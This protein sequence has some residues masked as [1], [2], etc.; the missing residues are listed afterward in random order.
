MCSKKQ[1]AHS[2]VRSKKHLSTDHSERREVAA[3]ELS[4][5]GIGDASKVSPGP[6]RR[7][8]ARPVLGRCL[9]AQT[10]AYRV[11][12]RARSAAALHGAPRPTA[13]AVRGRPSEGQTV[14][15]L[16][17]VRERRLF[18]DGDGQRGGRGGRGR[19]R[20]DIF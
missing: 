3:A 4:P 11:G 2:S 6:K 9:C 13:L 7:C 5:C 10:G 18:R 1:A 16:R 17:E 12:A 8:R 15:R 19:N 20:S 14:R